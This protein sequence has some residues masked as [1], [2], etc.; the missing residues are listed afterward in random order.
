MEIQEIEDHIRPR[1]TNGTI[2][3]NTGNLTLFTSETVDVT[4]VSNVNLSLFHVSNNSGSKEIS[5]LGR[6]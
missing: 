3:Y 2:D 6:R 5:I 4:P 1:I